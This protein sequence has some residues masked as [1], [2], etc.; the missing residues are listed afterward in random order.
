MCMCV[1][2]SVCLCVCVCVCVLEEQE[3]ERYVEWERT[4]HAAKL[5]AS[6]D[7]Q[8]LEGIYMH[9]YV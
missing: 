2:V 3:R 5:E 9:I 6:R 8:R 7:K 1:C 4:K